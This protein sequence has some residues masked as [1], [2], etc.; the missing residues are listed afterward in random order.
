[1]F[2]R[3]ESIN[4]VGVLEET[5]YADRRAGMRS[6]F[7]LNISSIPTFSL[8]RLSHLY[9]ELNIYCIVLTKDGMF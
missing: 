8:I 1:M 4:V 9:Q 7:K 5:E 6:F 3:M 2:G